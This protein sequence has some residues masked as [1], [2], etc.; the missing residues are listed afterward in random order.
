MPNLPVSGKIEATIEGRSVDKLIDAVVDTFSPATELAG[1][2]GDTVRLARVEVAAQIT[3]KAKIIAQKYNLELVA[4]PIKF[5]AP[6]Y[7]KSSLEEDVTL[8]DKWAELLVSASSAQNVNYNRY[9]SI[10]SELSSEHLLA[11]D[12]IIGKCNSYRDL[13]FIEDFIFDSSFPFA[14][15]NIKSIGKKYSDKDDVI[16]TI[17][18]DYD[19]DGALI[20]HIALSSPDSEHFFDFNGDKYK[21]SDELIYESLCSQGLLERVDTGFVATHYFD[22]FLKYY[23]VTALGVDFYRATHS[24]P[25]DENVA[26]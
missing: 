7:E 21:E 1:L 15:E 26:L 6:F 11:L 8:Q 20:V 14:V 25:A 3:R 22:I 18:R 5:L 9:I 13:E 19:K 24:Y 12:G 10:I 16:E 17:K 4:P 23:V 2:L